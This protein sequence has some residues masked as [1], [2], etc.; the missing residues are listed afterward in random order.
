MLPVLLD[1]K[2]IKI[3][4]FGI[5]LVLSFFWGS[6]MLWKNIRL[7][8]YKEEDIFDGLFLSLIGALFF[9]RLFYVILNFSKFGLNIL[10]FILINGYPGL[11]LIGLLFGGLLV[12]YL[13]F[14]SRKIKFM[15]AIDYFI[16]PLL[17]TLAI[18]KLGSFF[19]GSE[20]GTKAKFFLSVKYVGFDSYRHLTPLYEALLFF[21]GAYMAYALL[22]KIRREIFQKG[23]SFYFFIWYFCFIYFVFDKI[24]NNHLYFLGQSFN[25]V[26]SLILLLTTSFYFIYYFRYLIFQTLV[27]I[28]N[29]IK[30]YGHK[31]VQKIHIFPRKKT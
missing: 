29:S 6:F 3:Y 10:K 18:G 11:S 25:R 8:S 13:H 16:S 5:F 19:A 21:L 2:I 22:F 15:E 4:T 23:L 26:L 20:V 30:K 1:L 24:K 7:T 9:G 12:L 31:T 28:T 17:L 14:L 27:K